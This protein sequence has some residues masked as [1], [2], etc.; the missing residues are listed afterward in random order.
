MEGNL[1]N[2][3]HRKVAKEVKVS[4]NSLVTKSN[5]L[6]EARY[7]LTLREQRFI[8][9]MV[10]M[11]EPED[12][13]FTYYKV[14][15]KQ[16]I[17]ALGLGKEKDAYKR[18]KQIVRGLQTRLLQIKHPDGVVEVQWVG[19]ADY[20]KAGIIEF[21]FSTKLMPYLLQLQEQFTKYRLKN[22]VQLQSVYAI[23]IYELLKQY[24]KIGS[25]RMTVEDLRAY[26]GIEETKYKMYANLKDRVLKPA[27]KEVNE[28]TDIAF[29]FD[30]IKEGRKV[31]AVRFHIER[32]EHKGGLFPTP[33]D[34]P[35][36]LVVKE[37]VQVGVSKRQASKIW[38]E[39]W[40]FLNAEARQQVDLLITDGLQFDQYV[41]DKLEL[42]NKA[43]K[44]GDIPSR[45]GWISN[46]IKENWT[47]AEQ[48]KKRKRVRR[49]AEYQRRV[50][51]EEVRRDR[52]DAE[53]RN[54][55]ARDARMDAQYITLS[56]A[57]Q[58][59]INRL[60]VERLLTMDDFTAQ[61]IEIR[62][63]ADEVNSGEDLFRKLPAGI[64]VSAQRIR[65]EIVATNE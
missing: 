16:L 1:D 37:M 30:E 49:R 47:N 28:K 62:R 50:Q 24:E 14:P 21:E 25:R 34:E 63:V 13:A 22:I 15:S 26:L 8:L 61:R 2:K 57:Q 7:R 6:V 36:P 5:Y 38:R 19:S 59:R 58:E 53:A 41:R 20:R 35:L 43:S 51:E 60:V 39:K 64:R 4:D 40:G 42:L 33:L 55:R 54:K 65:R 32:N 12:S 31:V 23:R 45:G 3:R 17:E 10:S 18:L 48:D 29:T 52:E 11:I 44:Q 56:P 27:H 46:A 9:L